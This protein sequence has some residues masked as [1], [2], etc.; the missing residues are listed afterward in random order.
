[1]ALVVL[2]LCLVPV[3]SFRPFADNSE[4]F[5]AVRKWAHG[6]RQE[7]LDTYG[8][9]GQWDVSGV[10]DMSRLFEYLSHFDEDISAWNTSAVTDM[11]YMFDGASAFNQPIGAWNTSA[12][13]NMA[14]M[15]MHAKAFNSPIG[16]WDTSAVTNA[17]AC[18]ACG[19][20]MMMYQAECIWWHLPLILALVSFLVAAGSMLRKPWTPKA[21]QSNN[22]A[23][24]QAG[25]H[26]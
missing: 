22:S 2:L 14:G 21:Q 19:F 20:P 8:G 6:R 18:E 3:A 12:V 26:V 10:T 15:F 23:R 13:T 9:I 4:L 24:Q 7:L 1:M 17:K 11:R 25:A 16:A 5:K